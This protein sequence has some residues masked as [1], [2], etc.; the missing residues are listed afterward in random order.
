[1]ERHLIEILEAMDSI[2]GFVTLGYPS[3]HVYCTKALG[4]SDAQAYSLV[5]VARKFRKFPEIKALVDAEKLHL[6][7]AT[8]IARVIDPGNKD[9]LLEL[10]QS[11]SKR[12][13]EYEIKKIFPEQS[14]KERVRTISENQSE[15][16]LIIPKE[17]EGALVAFKIC[18]RKR[19]GAH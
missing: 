6:A 1:M 13:L 4:L 15:L 18:I 5:L 12:E 3:M 10:G 19:H 11:L 14:P 9:K 2:R 16:R 8:Q 7:N 17:L